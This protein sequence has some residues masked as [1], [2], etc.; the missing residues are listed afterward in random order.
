VL[1]LH[2]GQSFQIFEVR[3]FVRLA[4]FSHSLS[5]LDVFRSNFYF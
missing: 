2:G 1:Q 3:L 5:Y 4:R